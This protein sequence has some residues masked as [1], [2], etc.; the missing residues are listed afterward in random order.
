MLRP[1]RAPS[2]SGPRLACDVLVLFLCLARAQRTQPSLASWQALHLG[3]RCL[4]R[5]LGLGSRLLVAAAAVCRSHHLLSA[6]VCVRALALGAADP[7]TGTG[8]SRP[9]LARRL[10][11]RECLH[12][13]A[14]TCTRVNLHGQDKELR[15]ALH[16][17]GNDLWLA[18]KMYLHEARLSTLKIVLNYS[19][20]VVAFDFSSL[21]SIQARMAR[22][23][24]LTL[25]SQAVPASLSACSV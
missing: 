7:P 6:P 4:S 11:G 19:P 25:P 21:R 5:Y 3:R 13:H 9:S 16:G 8:S 15:R 23:Q 12:V 20:S 2:A 18:R 24:R 22:Q 14:W 10:L 17:E 1:T